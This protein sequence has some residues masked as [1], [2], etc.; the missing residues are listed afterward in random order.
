MITTFLHTIF[1]GGGGRGEGGGGTDGFSS[2]VDSV[3]VVVVV[4]VVD[5]VECLPLIRGGKFIDLWLKVYIV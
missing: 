2:H 5:S 3:V 1:I 4:V